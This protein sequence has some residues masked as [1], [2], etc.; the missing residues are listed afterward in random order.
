M[1]LR[2]HTV[3]I[4]T[5]CPLCSGQTV[6]CYLEAVF[7]QLPGQIETLFLSLALPY[8]PFFALTP[9]TSTCPLLSVV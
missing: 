9:F 7:W 5:S 3:S 8:I 6:P 4:A 2:C 1:S